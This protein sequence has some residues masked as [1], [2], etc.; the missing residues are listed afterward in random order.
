[1]NQKDYYR[2]LGVNENAASDEIKKAYRNLAFR[3]HPD[4]S[5]GNE[6]MMKEIN[7]AYAVLSNPV[8]RNE[9]DTLRQ[10]Y[11]SFARDQFRQTYNDQDIFRDSD[12]GQIFEELS[13]TFG[14]SK[15]EDIFTR[16][17]FYGPSYRSFEFKG[18]G[19][20]GRGFF[21]YGPLRG[22]YQ[23]RLKASAAHTRQAAEDGHPLLSTFM[24]KMASLLQ[25]IAAKKLGLELPESGRDLYDILQITPEEASAGSKVRYLYNKLGHPRDL[26][27]TLPQGIR[28]GQKI[29][30][31]GLGEAGKHGG[32]HGDLYLKVKI[33][34]PFLDRIK[35]FLDK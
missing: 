16:N 9:Y 35:S 20:S 5:T 14:F 24:G 1:M 13:R 3:Y 30:L 33:R 31:K 28:A 34:M 32:K 15:P 18:H 19:G 10:R 6:D 26:L 8:K 29:K 25:K 11:G 4:R 12:I 23:E 22:A 2:I 7:E 27:V 17:N 21:F